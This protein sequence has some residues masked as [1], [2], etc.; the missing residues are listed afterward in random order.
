LRRALALEIEG[1]GGADEVLQGR[2]VDLVAFTEVDGAPGVPLE[3]RVEQPGR[4]VQRSTLGERQLDGG[5]VGLAGAEDAS[6]GPDGNPPP[7]LLDDLRVGGLDESTHARERL[8][9]PVTELFDPPVDQLGSG[10]P[11][12]RSW[13]LHR[14][15]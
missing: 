8:S 1:R 14:A 9:S 7:P 10:F 13:T 2:L 4:V 12:R 11:V 15:D 6:V 3:A 5:L